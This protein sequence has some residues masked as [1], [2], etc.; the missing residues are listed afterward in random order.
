[1]KTEFLGSG[2]ESAAVD[3]G[4]AAD[5]KYG[6]G[7]EFAD[8]TA[9]AER[10]KGRVV[11]TP[12]PP[13]GALSQAAGMSV[14]CKLEYLQ[15]TGSFKE[16]GACNALLLLSP[17]QKQ[18]GVIAASAGNHA[19]GVT[20]HAML[21]GI[22]VTVVM[23]QTAPLT[24]VVN[25]QQ[26]GAHVILHGN[27]YEEARQEA[28]ELGKQE[29]LTLIH[30]FND[31]AVIAGQGTLGLEVLE[32]VPDLDAI[33]VPIG[34]AGLIAGVAMAIKSRKPEVRVIGVE[35]DHA[36]AY[37]SALKEGKPVLTKVRPTLADGLA[38]S[39][40]GE[41]SFQIARKFVDDVVVV[42]EADIARAVLRLVELEKAVVEGAGA[43]PLAACLA[44][45]VPELKGKKVVLP[46]C[47]GNID[48]TILGRVLER[49]LASDGRLCQFTATISDRPGGLAQFAAL[50]AGE[51]ANVVDIEHDRAFASGDISTVVVRC[52]VETRD[53]KH[54]QTLHERLRKEG[55]EVAFPKH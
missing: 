16:R 35:A 3:R 43:A 40:V 5:G 18:R 30:G 47:G 38:V 1:M 41:N 28:T 10:I 53:A 39:K 22:P 44:G 20:Y 49:G 55:F 21:Q 27:N 6:M 51:G 42:K 54:I 19:L 17:E 33:I 4:R 45:L 8:I 37:M 11:F 52:V 9:A 7:V 12:C 15:R 25:C 2:D 36:L 29:G 34:G 48:T 13:S 23:P 50:V 46:L 24:K 14:Y 26:M 31:R 32:Q